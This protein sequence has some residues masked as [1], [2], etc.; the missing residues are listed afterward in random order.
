VAVA[1]VG[2]PFKSVGGLAPL[3]HAHLRLARSGQRLLE[4]HRGDGLSSSVGWPTCL[5]VQKPRHAVQRH[6]RAPPERFH[7]GP[8]GFHCARTELPQASTSRPLIQS[9]LTDASHA[10]PDATSDCLG[11]DLVGSTRPNDR[12]QAE[13]RGQ[14]AGPGPGADR[15]APEA[16]H[17]STGWPGGCRRWCRSAPRRPSPGHSPDAPA[18]RRT[19]TATPPSPGSTPRPAGRRSVGR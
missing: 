6:E 2:M 7:R 14:G 8:V 5:T 18:T 19:P 3:P 9:A 4:P 1:V 12:G 16:T 10:P 15:R 17:K 11:Q 13:D